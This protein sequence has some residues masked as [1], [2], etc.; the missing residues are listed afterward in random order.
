MELNFKQSKTVQTI[1]IILPWDRAI[2][3]KKSDLDKYV[4]TMDTSHLKFNP[5]IEPTRFW[6]TELTEWV[7][8]AA[9]RI[10]SK[11]PG[12]EERLLFQYGVQ[13]ISH[14]KK[15]FL[16]PSQ[17]PNFDSLPFDKSFTFNGSTDWYPENS[18]SVPKHKTELKVVEDDEVIRFNSMTIKFIAEY[19]RQTNFLVPGTEKPYQVLRLFLP[20]AT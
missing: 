3:R 10:S 8:Q 14:L 4:E 6:I 1:P 12:H 20:A 13:K 2:D 7:S 17:F 11:L 16:N 15:E 5:G 9:E 18:Y 19:V